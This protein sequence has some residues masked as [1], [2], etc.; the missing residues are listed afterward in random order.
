MRIYFFLF[1]LHSFLH[2]APIHTSQVLILS[3]PL[4]S[5]SI[6]RSKS[7]HFSP[8]ISNTWVLLS[9]QTAW[10]D[11]SGKNPIAPCGKHRGGKEDIIVTITATI[12]FIAHDYLGAHTHT[13]TH[14][15]AHTYTDKQTAVHIWSSLGTLDS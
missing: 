8:E 2:F 14:T 15:R 5:R 6:S 7:A 12:I 3:R 9:V 10:Q 11:P 1:D 13:H 4:I